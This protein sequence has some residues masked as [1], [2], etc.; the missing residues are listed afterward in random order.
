[1][2]ERVIGVD[3]SGAGPA[4]RA[5]IYLAEATAQDPPRVLSAVRAADRAA[6]EAFL[7]GEPL[8][9]SKAWSGWKR[10][11]PLAA[12]ET[13]L[14]GLDFAFGFPR[15]FSLPGGGT[16]WSWERLADWCKGFEGKDELAK[17]LRAE[18]EVAKQFRLGPGGSGAVM[19]L[20][21]TEEELVKLGERPASV[22]NLVGAQQVGAGSIR[23]IPIL[24]RLR[25][26]R[27]AAVWPFDEAASRPITVVEVFPRLWLTAGLGKQHPSHRIEQLCAWEKAGIRF[28]NETELV[29]VA[30]ADAMDAVAAAIGLATESAI[31]PA[32]DLPADAEREGWIARVSALRRNGEGV[33]P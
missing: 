13:V 18:P 23:G 24:A 20:R 30:S 26:D 9:L 28:E 16:A 31:S 14:V 32:R 27:A 21:R 1:V 12:S 33:E 5:E 2:Y 15:Q 10:P 7:R 11:E 25:G 17:S 22:F 29:A 3:W 6:V 19:H 4:R 8:K